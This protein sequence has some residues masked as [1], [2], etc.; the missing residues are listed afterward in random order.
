MAYATQQL[1]YFTIFKIKFFLLILKLL[2]IPGKRHISAILI[3]IL[4]FFFSRKK[5]KRLIEC[6][7]SF[8]QT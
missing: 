1:N 6:F 3:K 5:K 7:R 2:E 8:D 4:G